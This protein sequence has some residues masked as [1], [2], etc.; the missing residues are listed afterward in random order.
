[1]KDEVNIRNQKQKSSVGGV[2]GV[3]TVVH[4]PKCPIVHRKYGDGS[5]A[6]GQLRE[7]K[8]AVR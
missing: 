1:Q 3:C 6:V 7:R 5:E 8:M 4:G 2:C